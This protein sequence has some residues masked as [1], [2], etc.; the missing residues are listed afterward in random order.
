[1]LDRLPTLPGLPPV[2]LPPDA[3]TQDAWSITDASPTKSRQEA[4][5]ADEGASW[6]VESTSCLPG[7]ASLVLC[8]E[9][10]FKENK[11]TSDATRDE[12]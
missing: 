5:E 10:L 1:M 4:S 9:S 11:T 12:W 8:A 7:Q 6:L 3:P 2:R